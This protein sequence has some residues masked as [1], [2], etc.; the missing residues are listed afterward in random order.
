MKIASTLVQGK[1][2][3]Q[4]HIKRVIKHLITKVLTGCCKCCFVQIAIQMFNGLSLKQESEKLSK[5]QLSL[6]LRS[7]QLRHFN[8]HRQ[9]E[10]KT[11]I[12]QLV[13]YHEYHKKKI[14]EHE[15][16][17]QKMNKKAASFDELQKKLHE[18]DTERKILESRLI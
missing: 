18:I 16:L 3:K 4:L 15:F 11:Q 2:I 7:N 9:K 1:S 17:L 6:L 12:D 8:I 5:N 14:D 13:L 10:Q